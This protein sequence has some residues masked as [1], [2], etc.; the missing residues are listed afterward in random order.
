MLA[1]LDHSR[2]MELVSSGSMRRSWEV[3]LLS[4]RVSLSSTSFGTHSLHEHQLESSSPTRFR[5]KSLTGLDYVPGFLLRSQCEWNSRG[6]VL[7]PSVF[8]PPRSCWFVRK[9]SVFIP[10][11]QLLTRWGFS[12]VFWVCFALHQPYSPH[13]LTSF[14]LCLRTSGLYKPFCRLPSEVMP[15]QPC[16]SS[17]G[18][19]RDI[20]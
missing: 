1:L 5:S 15:N 14:K 6:L 20:A 11:P 13:L 17:T 4:F 2:G 18:T 8:P 12:V 7:W 10:P 3:V 9:R 19:P 16:L